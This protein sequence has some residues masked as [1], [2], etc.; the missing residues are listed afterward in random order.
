M[1]DIFGEANKDDS[2]ICCL[3]R[4]NVC[5]RRDVG[6]DNY[7]SSWFFGLVVISFS[8]AAGASPRMINQ[9]ATCSPVVA[10]VVVAIG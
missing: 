2:L 7:L 4:A 1:Y 5:G 6:T 10:V 9:A 8:M 3:W